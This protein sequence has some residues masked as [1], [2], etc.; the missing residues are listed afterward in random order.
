MRTLARV[1]R[2][3]RR[4][5]SGRR[6]WS[7]AR[8][9]LLAGGFVPRFSLAI[10]LGGVRKRLEREMKARGLFYFAWRLVSGREREMGKT[11]IVKHRSA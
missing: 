11:V 6:I 1:V 3:E 8:P 10:A 2:R 4:R 7:D 5:S 9:F